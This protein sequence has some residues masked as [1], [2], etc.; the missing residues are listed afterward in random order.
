MLAGIVL[1]GKET[2][3]HELSIAHNL[4]ELASTAALDAGVSQ[5]SA[6]HLRLGLL[7]GVVPEALE[8]GFEI[9]AQGTPLAGAQLLIETVPVMVYCS[10]CH[11]TVLLANIQYF[12]CPVCGEPT[13]QIVQGRELEL[14]ALE[15]TTA[16]LPRGD[17]HA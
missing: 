5:V 10:A 6:V 12:Y 14:V 4:V 17:H 3:M 8:F 7:A 16:S 15:Y 2:C 9:A 11:E 1:L 13:S